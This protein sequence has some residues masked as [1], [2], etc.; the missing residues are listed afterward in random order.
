MKTISIC[1][2]VKNEEDVLPRAL[3]SV[4][5]IADEIIIADTGSEDK[6]QEIARDFTAF[7]YSF[8]WQDDFS[9]ARNTGL[10]KCTDTLPSAEEFDR[11]RKDPERAA[12]LEEQLKDIESKTKRAEEKLALFINYNYLN[13]LST[14]ASALRAS[15]CSAERAD[16]QMALETYK[17][18]LSTIEHLETLTLELFL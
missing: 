1:M 11:I 13:T 4:K 18:A 15:S 7:V 3:E 8:P 14:A 6:T 17:C 2:I 16:Y 10:K 9:K 5:N 12:L